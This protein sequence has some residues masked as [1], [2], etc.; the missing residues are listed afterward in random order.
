MNRDCIAIED[1]V[2]T[3]GLPG[4]DPARRHLESCP[5]CG[6]LLA[7]SRDFLEAPG[8]PADAGLPAA[9]DELSEFLR[10]SVTAGERGARPSGGPANR[11]R[12]QSLAHRLGPLPVR[13]TLFGAAVAAAILIV[14]VGSD[15]P[16][17]PSRD[18]VLRGA[19]SAAFRAI[20]EWRQDGGL[21][22]QWPALTGAD[23]YEVVLLR[24]DLSELRRVDAGE[25]CIV[26][27]DAQAIAPIDS[28]CFYRVAARRGGD[29]LQESPTQALPA[30]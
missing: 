9:E 30:R 16:T 8:L 23:R 25:A 20:V 6:A 26:M 14:R 2:R 18:P 3:A 21:Q 5:R 11:G 27:I 4:T 22:V 13:L 19:P 29:L 15:L 17:T 7:A 1:L 12:W 28:P 24:R 10:R